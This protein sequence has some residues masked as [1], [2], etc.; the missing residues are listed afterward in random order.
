MTDKNVKQSLKKYFILLSIF[1]LAGGLIYKT[2][3][4]PMDASI[5][6]IGGADGPTAIFISTS[7]YSCLSSAIVLMIVVIGGFILYKLIR[8]KGR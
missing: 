3:Y 2:I 6:I 4:E 8:K 5:G 1:V 7:P